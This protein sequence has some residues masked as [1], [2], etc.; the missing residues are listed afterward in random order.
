MIAS[1]SGG[2]MMD[3]GNKKSFLI[4]GQLLMVACLF[5]IYK[6]EKFDVLVILLVFCHTIAYCFSVGPLNMYY[7]S[8]MLRTPGYISVVNWIASFAVALSAKFM[9]SDL[10]IGNMCLSFCILLSICIVILMFGRPR[11]V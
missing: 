1:F 8:K 7:A 9:M 3:R 6:L 5:M 2:I 4:I 10:G 11:E